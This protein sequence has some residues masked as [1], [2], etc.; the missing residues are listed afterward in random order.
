MTFPDT[1]LRFFPQNNIAINIITTVNKPYIL[2]TY[3][4]IFILYQREENINKPNNM[5]ILNSK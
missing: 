2:I 4:N 1:L 5:T 3:F